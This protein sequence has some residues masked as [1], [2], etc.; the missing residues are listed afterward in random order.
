MRAPDRHWLI[1]ASVCAA[2]ALVHTWPL[3]LAPGTF[4]RNDNGDAQLNEWIL[5]WVA[6]Q[7]PRAPAHLFDANIFYP[8]RNTLAFSEPLIVPG[9][10]G[11]PIR[12]LGGS[13]VLTYN[14]VLLLGFA[15]T[16]W[17]T[18]A[19]VFAWTGD[20]IASLL[21]GS[22]FAFNTH[23]LT[24]LTH[25]QGIHAWGLPLALLSIDRL[26]SAGRMRDAIGLS[27][28]MAAL[29]Y[30]SGYLAVFGA[31]IVMVALVVRVSEWLPRARTVL[32]Q[33]ALSAGLSTVI[34]L[35][36]FIHYRRA[37]IE[38]GM[39]RSL[40]SVTA[41]SAGP[42]AYLASAG[43]IHYATWS[44]EFFRA[45]IDYFFPG[46]VALLLSA[47]AV[48]MLARRRVGID[49]TLFGRRVGM[50]VVIAIVG[51]ILSFGTRT[52]VYGWFYSAFP[53]MHGLRAATRFGNLFLLATA[54]LAG[55]GLASLR[56][57]TPALRTSVV[58]I[59]LIAAANV[60]SLRAPFHYT[61]F[62]GIPRVYLD[63]ASAPGR[64]VL[65]EIPF[66]PAGAIFEN[67]TY[68]L[69]STVHWRPIVNG[70]SGYIPRRY[71]EYA[72]AFRGFPHDDAIR[73]MKQA[74]VTHV[75]VHPERLDL[76]PGAAD[77]Y[78][79]ELA[80]HPFLE[81]LSIGQRGITLYRLR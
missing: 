52:P 11:A 58:G 43:R 81:R 79:K 54:V 20:R 17:A 56:R 65:A 31:V 46:F 50:L 13:P 34:V 53:P 36:L 51:L 28:S 76:D 73:A 12:W 71:N 29:A 4:C 69:N 64:V 24:R 30:T 62:E 61:T 40:E 18:Y 14:L 8:A 38:E 35:P 39:T 5:A 75:M 22:I 16:A 41:Y 32:P 27:L 68:Q 7:L 42:E 33:L 9:I 37:A 70:Y 3:A 26:I 72:E 21:A 60:E 59:A 47:V 25:V 66:Y 15:L 48:A 23:T 77:A 10:M 45:S 19:L 78:M 2:L 49:R 57:A 1:A 55:L 74:G 44:G 63:V 67:A 80:V 6:H